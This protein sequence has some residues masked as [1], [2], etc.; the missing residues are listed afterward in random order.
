MKVTY[1]G[2]PYDSDRNLKKEYAY[3]RTVATYR[4]IEYDTVKKVEVAK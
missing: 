3:V 1:R 2:V 4:G